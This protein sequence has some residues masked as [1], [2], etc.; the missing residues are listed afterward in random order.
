MAV[1]TLMTKKA[2]DVNGQYHKHGLA[3]PPT[4]ESPTSFAEAATRCNTSIARKRNGVVFLQSRGA[5]EGFFFSPSSAA[6]AACEPTTSIHTWPSLALT[7]MT[8]AVVVHSPVTHCLPCR[9]VQPRQN[10]LHGGEKDPTHIYTSK[11]YPL[12]YEWDTNLT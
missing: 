10:V 8:G 6:S 11:K 1:G 3:V 7:T 9:E 12:V 4:H 2:R 5:L